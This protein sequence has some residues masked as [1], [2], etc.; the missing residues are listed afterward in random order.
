VL[1]ITNPAGFVQ[2]VRYVKKVVWEELLH[3]W[4]G[5]KLLYYN[6][7][8][9]KNLLYGVL[10]GHN[11]TRRERK[12]LTRTAAD[13]FRVVPFSV[14]I[15]VPFMELLLPFFLKL[16]PNM[17]PSTFKSSVQVQEDMKRTLHLRLGLAKFLQDTVEEMARNVK[18][19]TVDGEYVFLLDPLDVHA[20]V[21]R[22]APP[23]TH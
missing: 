10:Q 5:T 14:F 15:I 1:A 21:F 4:N 18:V 20:F 16:F 22:R 3:Y 17:L 2:K 6:V 9:T 19:R 8:S 13:V 11:L 23:P 12:L 7:V